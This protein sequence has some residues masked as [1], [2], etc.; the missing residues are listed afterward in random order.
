VEQPDYGAVRKTRTV[1]QIVLD[2]A[3]PFKAI[4]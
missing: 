2:C 4:A 3:A 1:T